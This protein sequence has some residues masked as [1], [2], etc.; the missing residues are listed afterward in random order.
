MGLALRVSDLD[1]DAFDDKK[2]GSLTLATKLCSGCDPDV[3]GHVERK[4]CKTCRGTGREP[5]SFAGAFAEIVESKHE[6]S[7]PKKGSWGDSDYG[8][9][10][11]EDADGDL[12]Y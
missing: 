3:P 1:D 12:E 4:N 10:G 5:L 7:H 8:D 9:D 6:E 11:D 2:V